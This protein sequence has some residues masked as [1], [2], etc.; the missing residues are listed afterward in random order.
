MQKKET[1]FW[2]Y[3]SRVCEQALKK[4]VGEFEQ[5]HGNIKISV[6]RFEENDSFF[7][8]EGKV[9]I[10]E[11]CEIPYWQVALFT[12]TESVVYEAYYLCMIRGWNTCL[13]DPKTKT[14]LVTFAEG[15]RASKIAH[16]WYRKGSSDKV[17]HVYLVYKLSDKFYTLIRRYGKRDGVFRQKERAF[18]SGKEEAE[19]EWHR[20][21]KKKLMKGYKQDV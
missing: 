11:L 19:E 1:E 5:K 13:F 4:F 17:Y 15:L 3:L 10:E 8:G 7:Q 9:V 12:P 20:I 21:F 16:L 6:N 18:N 14:V 2:L